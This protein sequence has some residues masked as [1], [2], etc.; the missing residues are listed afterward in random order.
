VKRFHLLI[1]ALTAAKPQLPDLEAVIVGEGY[2]RETLE[3]L[4]RERGAE[5]WIS[6][7]GRVDDDDLIDLYRRAWVVASTSAREGWGMTLTEAAACGTPAVAT[8]IAG[9]RDAVIDGESGVLVG[10]IADFPGALERVLTDTALRERLAAGAIARAA[11][12]TWD[13][14]ALGTLEALAADARRRA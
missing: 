11:R 3:T 5:D 14:T 10:R 7:P 12:C 4:L 1:D 13:A 6:L 9:H 8:D 2:Q